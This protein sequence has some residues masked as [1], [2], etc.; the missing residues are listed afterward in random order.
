MPNEPSTVNLELVEREPAL[1]GLHCS[2]AGR[3]AWRRQWR[4]LGALETVRLK[5]IH[6][7][8][9][10]ARRDLIGARLQLM[11]VMQRLPLP[12]HL[13]LLELLVTN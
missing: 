3:Q 1:I 2:M 7:Q 9:M 4:M 11:L 8:L 12:L 6:G 13:I 10:V 5:L